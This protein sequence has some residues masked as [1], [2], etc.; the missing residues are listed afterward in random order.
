M[1]MWEEQVKLFANDGL[2]DDWFGRSVG[3]PQDVAVVGSPLSDAVLYDGGAVYV[4]DN[5]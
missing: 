5:N 2:P 3:I 1:M 4:Y